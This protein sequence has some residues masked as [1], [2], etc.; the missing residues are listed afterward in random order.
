MAPKMSSF[1]V[2]SLILVHHLQLNFSEEIQY[3][4]QGLAKSPGDFLRCMNTSS[5]RLTHETEPKG[6]VSPGGKE[7]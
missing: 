2:T 6:C 1:N 7:T 4:I 3:G 5:S